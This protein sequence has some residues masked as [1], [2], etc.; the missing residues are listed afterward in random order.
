MSE[1]ANQ[2]PQLLSRDELLSTCE[3]RFKTV[4]PLPVR[5]GYVRLR[6]LTEAEASAYDAAKFSKGEIIQSRLLDMNCRF[7]SLCVVD[8]AGNRLLGPTD[9]A[10]LM[11]WDRADMEY[12]YTE[13]RA[14]VAAKQ[15][16][17]E[18]TEKNSAGTP[19]AG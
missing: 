14:H 6:S 11:T 19:A 5:G 1:T 17:I 7:I 8:Q 10:G 16:P 13:A 9:I 18:D 15:R 3:R 2:E 4:G 12:L